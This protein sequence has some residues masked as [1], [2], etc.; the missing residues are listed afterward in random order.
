MCLR[1]KRSINA[2][3]SAGRATGASGPTR[4]ALLEG[5]SV[6]MP[7]DEDEAGATVDDEAELRG[8]GGC[9]APLGMGAGERK[10]CSVGMSCASRLRSAATRRLPDAAVLANALLQRII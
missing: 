8:A 4:A 2:G 7:T 5:S 3:E 6:R 9:G 1:E 10:S